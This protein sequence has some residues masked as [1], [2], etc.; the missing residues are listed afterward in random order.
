M[1]MSKKKQFFKLCSF[2][3][4]T[5]PQTQLLF[6]TISRNPFSHIYTTVFMFVFVSDM[7]QAYAALGEKVF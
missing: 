5:H 1:L 4:L 2:N 3:S 7:T 6:Y